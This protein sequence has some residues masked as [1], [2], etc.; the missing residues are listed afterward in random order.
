M[1]DAAHDVEDAPPPYCIPADGVR[2]PG[3]RWDAGAALWDGWAG[4][5]GCAAAHTPCRTSHQYAK[6]EAGVLTKL[7]SCLVKPT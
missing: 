7:V 6:A 4:L 3:C 1:R 5:S 2:C